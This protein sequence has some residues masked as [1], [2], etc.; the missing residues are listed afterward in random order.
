MYFDRA[1]N[2]KDIGQYALSIDVSDYY[3]NI[4]KVYSVKMHYFISF[5]CLVGFCVGTLSTSI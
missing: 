4:E 5:A 2:Y 3:T 1:N